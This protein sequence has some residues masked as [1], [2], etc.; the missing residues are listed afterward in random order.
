MDIQSF[1]ESGLLESYVLGQCSAEERELVLR[2]VAQHPEVRAELTAVEQA[3]EGYAA[4]N[5]VTPPDWMKGRILDS[6][7]DETPAPRPNGRSGGRRNGLNI[8]VQILSLVLAFAAA[9]LF[10]QNSRL[11]TEKTSLEAA[12]AKLRAQV[13]DC[14]KRDQESEQLKKAVVLLRD[15][16]TR[17]VPLD[18]GKGTA[19]AYYNSVRKEVALDLGGLPAPEHKKYFQFWAIVEGKPVSMGMV[20][21]QSTDGWQLLPYIEHATALA[22]SQED[23]PTGSPMPTQ[24]VMIGN[25]PG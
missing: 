22:V 11:N 25:I 7:K 1:I 14:I 17:F 4:A 18:N 9:V 15:R 24:V 2:M 3:L 5:A 21:L 10:Y 6:I 8:A 13:D 12:N 19:Y 23:S 16:D 20:N